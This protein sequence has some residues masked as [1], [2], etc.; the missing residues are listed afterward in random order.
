MTQHVLKKKNN[1]I[2][3]LDKMNKYSWLVTLALIMLLPLMVTAGVRIFPSQDISGTE[4]HCI[5]Q[6]QRGFVWIGTDYG[7]NRFDGYHFQKYFTS[8][9]NQNSIDDNDISN[10]FSD[11]E[12]RLWIGTNHGLALYNPE[13]DNFTRKPYPDGMTHRVEQTY[14]DSKGNI[15]VATAGGGLYCIQKGHD[16]LQ[17]IKGITEQDWF[18]YHLQELPDG[19]L[20]AASFEGS[21]FVY[22]ISGLTLKKTERHNTGLGRW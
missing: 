7:L 19:R 21:Y 3:T 2:I 18:L 17:A 1:L 10:I 8:K 22:T 4:F 11:R 9:T 14:E 20:L 6:D 5:A 12:G 15:W 13:K 16:E